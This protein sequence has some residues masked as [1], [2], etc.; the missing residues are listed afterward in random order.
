MEQY[1]SLIVGGGIAGLQA[2]IQLGRYEH[3]VLVID[4]GYGRSTLC[5]SYHN[6]LGWPDGISG[7]ELRR[8]GRLQAEKLGVAFIQDEVVQAVKK[9]KPGDGFEL[10]GKSGK[11]YEAP[12]VLLAT[13]LMDRLPELPKLKECLG[14]TVYVCPDC[15]GYEI[16][17]KQTVIMGSG[18]VGAGMALKLSSRTDKL[19]YVNHGQRVVQ[20]ELLEQMAHKGIA[21]KAE[22]IQEVIAAG[23]GVFGGVVLASG[24]RIEAER[25]FIA[26][27]GNEVKSDLARQLGAER[28]EN[29]HII[30]DSR[31]KMTSV[32]FVWAAGDVGV[33]AEQVTIAMG[34]GAQAAIWMNKALLMLKEEANAHRVIVHS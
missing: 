9:G 15:D 30:T 17:N 23:K 34:E 24:H 22:D 32:P 20:K 19:V 6:L 2:A 12:T 4:A 1:D 3:R 13:G 8:L 25:G 21:Y 18:D 11:G 5:Q 7:N 29:R 14:L 26:F 28:M 31:S 33:H 16:K 27:G 10:W